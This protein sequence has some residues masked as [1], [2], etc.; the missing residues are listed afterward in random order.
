MT[1]L[2][3][4]V[5]ILVLLSLVTVLFFGATGWKRGTDRAVCIMNIQNVQKAVR[6]YAN[7]N[8]YAPG[9][10]APNLKSQVIGLGRFLGATPVCPGMG[11]YSFGATSGIDTVPPMG[12]LYM[13]CSLPL[14]EQHEPADHD[15]W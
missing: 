14:I 13:K 4:T 12:E 8:G 9:T 5:V 3:M 11:I 1:L 15:G 2:E 10:I 6:G 7:L